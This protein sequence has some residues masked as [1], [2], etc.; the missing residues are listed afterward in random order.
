MANRAGQGA[1][2][3][4]PLTRVSRGEDEAMIC[5]GSVMAAPGALHGWSDCAGSFGVSGC[6]QRTGEI[7][8]LRVIGSWAGAVAL[9]VCCCSIRIAWLRKM[10]RVW[11]CREARGALPAPTLPVLL[12]KG[13]AEHLPDPLHGWVVT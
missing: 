11:V 4:P 8:L 5:L 3:G 6:G 7:E 10:L 12:R 2:G 13:V 9:L 1:S